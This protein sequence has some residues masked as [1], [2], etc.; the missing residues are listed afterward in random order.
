VRVSSGGSE[1]SRSEFERLIPVVGGQNSQTDVRLLEGIP[2]GLPDQPE[3]GVA[4]LDGGSGHRNGGEQGEQ[5]SEQGEPSHGGRPIVG[6]H[7]GVGMQ[8]P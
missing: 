2:G 4:A 3:R 5:R 6:A 7:A 1:S 8:P